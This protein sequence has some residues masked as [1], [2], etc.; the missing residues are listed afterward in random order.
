MSK[1]P[2]TKVFIL[3]GLAIT[4]VIAM[5]I[6]IGAGYFFQKNDRAEKKPP[7][8]GSK[9]LTP[10]SAPVVHK[11]TVKNPGHTE[12]FAA[13]FGVKTTAETVKNAPDQLSSL[14]FMQPFTQNRERFQAF[15]VKTQTLEADGKTV[16][17]SHADAANISVVI[18]KQVDE[19]WQ[20]FAKQAN[21]G[22]FGSWGDVPDIKSAKTLSLSPDNLAF[23]I[24]TGF[25]GQGYTEQGKG[26]FSFNFKTH[27]WKDIGFVQ[28]GGDNA[29]ACDD[30]AQ[31]GDDLLFACWKFSGEITVA[32]T[33]KNPDYPDLLV[34][35][36]GTTSDQ[37]H[38]IV[39]A[40][41]QVY[42]FDGEHY[43]HVET[44]A[45]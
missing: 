19:I 26:M 33:G 8:A 31:A 17:N 24:D 7:I 44:K 43:V 28:T 16:L 36:K 29:G 10:V 5:L 4:A 38:K 22:S 13:L 30:D 3:V 18:Y 32:K 27:T 9:T 39:P 37:T 2:A 41:N 40:V 45:R 21:V 14:W 35:H 11:D 12:V 25:S 42:I 15:F 34:K 6:G 1:T 20:L 23:L